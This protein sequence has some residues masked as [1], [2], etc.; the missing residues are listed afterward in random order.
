M[1]LGIPQ[2]SVPTGCSVFQAPLPDLRFHRI[3]GLE[4][5]SF[6][7]LAVRESAG[8]G[9]HCAPYSITQEYKRAGEWPGHQLASPVTGGQPSP[10][11]NSG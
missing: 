4:Y 5:L 11:F 3:W 2:G 1:I 9:L 7:A 6:P 10:E 8:G